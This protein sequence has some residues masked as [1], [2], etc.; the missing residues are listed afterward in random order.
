MRQFDDRVRLRGVFVSFSGPG[1]AV[2][3]STVSGRAC[4]VVRR[5]VETEAFAR[6]YATRTAALKLQDRHL[7]DCQQQVRRI[8]SPLIADTEIDRLSIARSK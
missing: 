3:G 4:V 6:S 7:L 5:P 1:A 2:F 8:S